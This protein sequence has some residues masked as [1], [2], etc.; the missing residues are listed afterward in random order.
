M[1][2]CHHRHGPQVVNGSV[3]AESS[4]ASTWPTG[5]HEPM[6][7]TERLVSERFPR[8]SRYDPE[9]ILA[10]V[11]G[12]ANS[13]WLTEWLTEAMT[14]RP[15]AADQPGAVGERP[16]EQAEHDLV[17]PIPQE[18]A[19]Q[20]RGELRRRQLQRDHG[21]SE[22]QRDDGHHRPGDADEHRPGVVRG[23]LAQR[24]DIDHRRTLLG[25]RIDADTML[26]PD[27]PGQLEGPP[28]GPT[29][30]EGSR[31]PEA[32]GSASPDTADSPLP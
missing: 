6:T 30:A 23:V 22:Q 13:L 17:R 31:G 25:S 8:S 15:V 28:S 10:G 24:V 27:R 9:W 16:H 21:E 4:V 7:A 2:P 19:Q 26:T 20:P 14:L 1:A 18:V 29:R 12:G 5:D 32:S 3:T 11:A